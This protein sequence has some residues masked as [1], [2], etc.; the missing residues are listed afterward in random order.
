MII[1]APEIVMP[2]KLINSYIDRVIYLSHPYFDS[3]W[4]NYRKLKK[5]QSELLKKYPTYEFTSAMFNLHKTGASKKYYH[6]LAQFYIIQ[7]DEL[8]IVSPKTTEETIIE[9]AVAKLERVPM[10]ELW[11]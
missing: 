2:P 10:V 4:N 1:H 11:T 6:K 9:M 5:V 3:Q 8:W 7:S